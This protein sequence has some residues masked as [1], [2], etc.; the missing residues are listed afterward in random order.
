M[1]AILGTRCAFCGLK[2]AYA[3]GFCPARTLIP[4]ERLPHEAETRG[5]AVTRD[6]FERAAQRA[7]FPGSRKR[8]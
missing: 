7:R 4:G 8:R 5:D 6:N 1:M 3:P 2:I